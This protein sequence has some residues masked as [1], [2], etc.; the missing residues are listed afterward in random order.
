MIQIVLLHQIHIPESN[1]LLSSLLTIMHNIPYKTS[2]NRIS[3][4]NSTYIGVEVDVK[5]G[6]SRERM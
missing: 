3:S 2:R 5:W 4:R 1:D 6:E